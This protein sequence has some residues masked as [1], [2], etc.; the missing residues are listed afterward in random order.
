MGLDN[1]AAIEQRAAVGPAYVH[2]IV[3][4]DTVARKPVLTDNV[5]NCESV[6]EDVSLA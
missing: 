5:D 2:V 1:G 4:G 6:F 3:D